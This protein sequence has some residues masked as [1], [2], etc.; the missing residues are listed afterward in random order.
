MK[1]LLWPACSNCGEPAKW[2]GS[3]PD[4]GGV[5]VCEQCL[6]GLKR[7]YFEL[8]EREEKRFEYLPPPTNK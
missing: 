5:P 4:A 2:A 7:K 1:H 8:F 6:G 3:H